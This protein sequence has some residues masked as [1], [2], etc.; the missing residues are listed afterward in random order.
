MTP[1][2]VN[3]ENL[4][5]VVSEHQRRLDHLESRTEDLNVVR[6]DLSTLRQDVDTVKTEMG[7]LR[8]ALYTAAISVAG[9]AVLF[10]GG[11]F[12]LLK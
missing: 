7:A 2:R 9:S 6:R 4:V 3:Q 10:V 11:L 1:D 8:R 5:F 12:V